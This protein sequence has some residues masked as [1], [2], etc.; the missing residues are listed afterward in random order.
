MEQTENKTETTPQEENQVETIDNRSD[1]EIVMSEFTA[2]DENPVEVDENPV[3]AEK[4]ATPQADNV[5]AEAKTETPVEVDYKTKYDELNK[6]LEKYRSVEKQEIENSEKKAKDLGFQSL[7]EKKIYDDAIVREFQGLYREIDYLTP[8]LKAQAM[9]YLRRY[10]VSLDDVSLREVKR[11]ISPD[12][13]EKIALDRENF[14]KTE[15]DK[16]NRTKEEQKYE[17]IK[18]RL[19]DFVGQNRAWFDTPAK[20]SA[21][22]MIVDS[23]G[24]DADLGKVK[25]MIDTI[26]AE[27][28]KKYESKKEAETRKQQ[29][30]PINNANLGGVGEKWFTKSEIDKMSDSDYVKNGEKIALQMSLEKQGKLPRTII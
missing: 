30:S 22:T 16:L 28:I 13:L 12:A 14:K 20:A 26:E 15:L 23:F 6:E 27:A 18:T 24:L 17:T 29:L 25:S 1:A 10:S 19:T 8:E 9:E 5:E 2:D 3:E 4:E 11:F 21:I 7:E